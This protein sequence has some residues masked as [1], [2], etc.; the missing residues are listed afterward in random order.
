MAVFY[1]DADDEIT[2]AATRI[3]STE[4][5]DVAL[6]L[7]AG[8][9]IATSRINF[10]LLAREAQ[11]R[12]RRLSIVAPEASARALAASA[13]MPVF[14][15]VLEYE[16]AR[17]APAPGSAGVG[18]AES[19]A[20][21]AIPDHPAVP[22]AGAAVVGAS[23]VAAARAGA[24]SQPAVVPLPSRSD[25]RADGSRAPGET[26]AGGTAAR[27][28][29]SA[30][31]VAPAVTRPRAG[32]GPST[33]LGPPPASTPARRRR[34]PLAA[35]G[36]LTLALVAGAALVV[37]YVLLPAATVTLSLVAEPVEPVAFVGT[38]DPDAL[39]V[40]PQTATIP[41]VRMPIPLS[42]TGTFPATGKRVVASAATGQVRWTNCDPTRAYTIPQGI[43]V[44]T[45]GGI[46]FA[47]QEVVFVPVATISPS[48]KLTCQNRTV[49]VRAVLDGPAGNVPAGTITVVPGQY[50]SVVIKVV[51]LVA[52]SGGA[53]QEFPQVSQKDVAAAVAQLTKQ[54]DA[55][56]VAGAANPQGVPA[57]STAYPE[58]ARRGPPV[59]S[60]AS[61]DLVGQEVATFDLTL[62]ADGTV[63]AADPSPLEAIAAARVAGNVP[64]GMRLVEGSTTVT[65]GT[66]LATGE[67]VHFPV[68]ARGQAVRDISEQEVRDLVKGKTPAEATSA[69]AGYG[70]LDVSL[71]PGWVS[72]ITSVDAR[73]SVSVVGVPPVAPG[74]T[75]APQASPATSEAPGQVSPAPA[76]APPPSSAA[77]PASVPPPSATP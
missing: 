48:L 34:W 31:V 75:P 51:N 3:R 44:R 53:R 52:T 2:T 62:T 24:L 64:A 37:G 73:L 65:I 76:S 47:T 68:Q 21:S 43:Q 50:N 41:A 23:G 22:A 61:A 32:P 6:V 72:T 1:L 55:Q 69:L 30:D 13:G 58:T 40:D 33:G 38:A 70:S 71:W 59:P 16:E 10:R 57:G 49:S 27:T 7:P 42:A 46:A 15:S 8:S 39:A 12:S 54:L 63:V 45:P 11:E 28:S 56:L 77:P 25:A 14:A 67:L 17:A 20:P 19:G 60:A 74:A 9:R 35:A 36:L 29:P 66:G 5:I 18:A 4:E 26:S